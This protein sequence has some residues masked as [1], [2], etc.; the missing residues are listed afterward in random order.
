MKEN[1]KGKKLIVLEDDEISI[2]LLKALLEKTQAN[3]V[4][5]RNVDEFLDVYN[6]DKDVVLLDIRMSGE[7]NGI[8]VLKDIKEKNPDQ[9]VIMQTAY[10]EKRKECEDLGADEFLEKPGIAKKLIPTIIKLLNKVKGNE[11]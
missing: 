11:S 3:T 8:D 7:K 2:F 10:P 4:Y 1:L 5:C 6:G 9:K